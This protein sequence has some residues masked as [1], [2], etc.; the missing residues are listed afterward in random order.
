MGPEDMFLCG[1]QKMLSV[2][3]LRFLSGQSVDFLTMISS[4]SYT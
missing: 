1:A 4:F 2:S 3:F